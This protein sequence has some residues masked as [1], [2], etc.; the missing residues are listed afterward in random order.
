MQD[1]FILRTPL[2]KINKL[3]NS[4]SELLEAYKLPLIRQAL[5]VASKDLYEQLEHIESNEVLDNKKRTKTIISLYKYYTRMCTRSTPFGLFSGINLGNFSSNTSISIS[6]NPQLHIKLDMDYLCNLYYELTKEISLYPYLKYY[7]NPTLYKVLDQWRF[8]E[9]KFKDDVRFHNIVSISDNEVLSE[10]IYKFSNGT[11]Y[12][13]IKSIILSYRFENDEA[14]LYIN[15]LIQ[16]QILISNLYPSVSGE[17]Y[18]TRLF[19]ELGKLPIL[20][21]KNLNDKINEILAGPSCIIQKT[22]QVQHLLSVFKM[23]IN[24]NHLIQVDLLKTV[25][26]AS[27]TNTIKMQVVEATNLLSRLAKSS[28]KS[29]TLEKFK[30]AF[31]ERYED[32]FVPLTHVMDPDLGIGYKN[33]ISLKEAKINTST[34]IREKQISS[35]KLKLYVKSLKEE[36]SSVEITDQQMIH[37]DKD[38]SH[39]LSNSYAFLGGLF[40]NKKKEI[41][42]RYKHAGGSS[43]INLIGRFGSLH[44]SIQEFGV[45]LTKLEEE[46]YANAII[47]EIVHLPQGRMGNV[48]SRPHYRDFEIPYLSYSTCSTEKQINVDDLYIGVINFQIIL[49]SK[50]NKKEVIPR[51]SNAHNYSSDSLPLY[52]FLCDLQYQNSASSVGWFWDELHD[53]PFLPRVTY[54][55]IILSPCRWNIQTSF[56]RAA[57]LYKNIVD[58]YSKIKELNLPDK[59][60][61]I[62]GDNELYIDIKCELGIKTFLQFCN[63][64]EKITLEEFLFN[65]DNGLDGYANEVII[66]FVQEK[67]SKYPELGNINLYLGEGQV[68]SPFSQ[69]VY[70]KV[71]TGKKYIEKLLL[72][73]IPFMVNEL[74]NMELINKWFFIRYSDPKSHLRLRFFIRNQNK[75]EELFNIVNKYFEK[76]IQEHIIAEMQIGTYKPEINRYGIDTIIESEEWFS[77]NSEMTLNLLPLLKKEDTYNQLVY[78]VYFI[79]LLFNQFEFTIKN[80]FEFSE[81][82]FSQYGREFNVA[83]SKVLRQKLS[84]DFRA[85][86]NTLKSMM[87]AFDYS[88]DSPFFEFYQ[89]CFKYKEKSNLI[90][91]AIKRKQNLNIKKLNMIVAGFIHMFINRLYMEDPRFKEMSIYYFLYKFYSS[92]NAFKI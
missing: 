5:Y 68:F 74:K 51:L 7:P 78:A 90:I 56:F 9:Y 43:A 10:L 3:I 47:A 50:K 85:S 4:E 92:K 81:H 26:E 35:F 40:Y 54:K 70:L 19:N 84:I 25:K 82:M 83:N 24:P 59:F 23:K 30:L 69:W 57:E 17:E 38:P 80:K 48:I 55:N 64:N 36:T 77:Y 12:K 15:E 58:F 41:F 16:N 29:N 79:D 60:L 73:I 22:K 14:E 49:Y 63:K 8:I 45:S 65:S 32:S 18:Q 67:N 44:P 72:E 39:S 34:S 37:F 1:T 46:K 91:L 33:A 89:I 6:E 20:E 76:Y 88:S 27:L 28:K 52:H 13:N 21:Y 11:S 87:N 71:Y 62:Q 2:L 75:R 31:Y 86:H 61:I 53:E 42:I 66:P